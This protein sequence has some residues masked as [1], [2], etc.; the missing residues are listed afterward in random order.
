MFCS[1]ITK[2]PKSTTLKFDFSHILLAICGMFI[3]AYVDMRETSNIYNQQPIM[4]SMQ[5][6]A[7]NNFIVCVCV[8]SYE[9]KKSL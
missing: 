5:W 4:S 1:A 8:C 6:S 7:S 3:H 2:L 9:H